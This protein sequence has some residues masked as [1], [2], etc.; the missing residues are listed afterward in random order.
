MEPSTVNISNSNYDST[1][2]NSI[3]FDC[4]TNELQSIN[5]KNGDKDDDNNKKVINCDNRKLLLKKN[6]SWTTPQQNP[7]C[8][9]V[10]G[11][12]CV[13]KSKHNLKTSRSN[14]LVLETAA[15]SFTTHVKNLTNSRLKLNPN[16]TNLNTN[17]SNTQQQQQEPSQSL[18]LQTQTK[19]LA[20][21]AKAISTT[22]TLTAATGAT[23]LHTAATTP[24]AIT[25]QFK[26]RN[27]FFHILR[28]IFNHCKV[29]ILNKKHTKKYFYNTI[30]IQIINKFFLDNYLYDDLIFYRLAFYLVV[31]TYNLLNSSYNFCKAIFYSFLMHLHFVRIILSNF[32]TP[33]VGI[34]DDDSF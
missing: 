13:D 12:S 22:S 19:K 34:F 1:K 20:P 10:F 30:R 28:A 32:M 3:I 21:L 18:Q 5:E 15:N 9:D 27:S 24:T 17:N 25:I 29:I 23:A 26:Q 31:H 7:H 16:H 14:P 33:S 4:E 6:L 11:G 2:A 8:G